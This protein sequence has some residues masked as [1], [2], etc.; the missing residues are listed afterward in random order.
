MWWE[1]NNRG[2]GYCVLRGVLV[3]AEIVKTTRSL[4]MHMVTVLTMHGFFGGVFLAARAGDAGWPR[5]G[6]VRVN[7]QWQMSNR[8]TGRTRYE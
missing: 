6:D 4:R 2:L 8:L 1:N 7:Q 3:T 5:G